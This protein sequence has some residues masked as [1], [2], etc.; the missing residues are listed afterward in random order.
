[1]PAL[2][3]PALIML[4]TVALVG[5]LFVLG[6]AHA[7]RRLGER[8][9]LTRRW[10]LA[11][12]VGLALWLGLSGILAARGALADFT[13]VPPPLMLL[14]A[15]SGLITIGLACSPL[16]ARLELGL[17]LVWLVGFQAFRVPV[18]LML[19]LL[20]HAGAAP[21][22]MSFEGRNF[23]IITGLS[24]LPIAWL[25]ARGRLPEWGLQL[26]NLLG[27][28]LLLNIVVISI[29][30]LPLPIRLFLD[31]PANTIV[32]TWPFVWLPA[33]LVQAALFGHLLILRRLL[34]AARP[35]A[36][37]AAPGS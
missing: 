16:G 5:A 35:T 6:V 32:A 13:R 10:T 21:V 22:Q 31:E 29:L 19:A 18:E 25:A 1:M 8:P 34:R 37:L 33:F 27:L 7:G 23:D 17:P 24:A 4:A 12:G 30:S 20:V 3:L 26:W 11:A 36:R 28:G 14:V 15:A 9:A 2:I